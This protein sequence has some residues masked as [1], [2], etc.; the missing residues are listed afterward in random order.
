MSEHI[1]NLFHPQ[2]RCHSMANF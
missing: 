2:G 1:T